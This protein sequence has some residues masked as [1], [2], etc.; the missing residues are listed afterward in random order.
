[1][2]DKVLMF[3]CSLVLTLAAAAT[4]SAMA[5]TTKC[6]PGGNPAQN[7]NA[8]KAAG[9]VFTQS[10]PNRKCVV[11]ERPHEKECD[12]HFTKVVTPI[13]TY[14]RKGNQCKTTRDKKETC[15]DKDGKS[16]PVHQC[17]NCK[18]KPCDT[19]CPK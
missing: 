17:K 19:S 7:A 18:P 12:N 10:G 8:C 1:M 13:T 2:K 14:T 16:C 9:G 6:P 11:S 15:H 4:E 5:G 3:M